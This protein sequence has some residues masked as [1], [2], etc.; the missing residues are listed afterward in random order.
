MTK[1]E[2]E[3]VKGAL[4][5][6]QKDG[7]KKESRQYDKERMAPHIALSLSSRT[8]EASERSHQA[9]PQEAKEISRCARNDKRECPK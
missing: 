2:H 4:K 7:L 8:S 9:K 6:Q 5:K 3:K 1:K